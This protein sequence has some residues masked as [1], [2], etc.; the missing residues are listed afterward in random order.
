[1]ENSN[2]TRTLARWARIGDKM[3]KG[4]FE[5]LREAQTRTP[6][7]A[8]VNEGGHDFT[9]TQYILAWENR[10]HEKVFT[11]EIV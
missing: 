9:N 4:S 11:F 1:M 3:D 2:T 8:I 6:I 10:F 7:Q 5:E